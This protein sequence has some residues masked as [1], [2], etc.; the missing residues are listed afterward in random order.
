MPRSVTFGLLAALLATTPA[1][2]T[3][4][5]GSHVEA[6]VERSVTVHHRV[7]VTASHHSG[8]P[9]AGARVAV[10]APGG[11]DQPWTTG[12]CDANGRFAFDL[13][14]DSSGEWRVTVLE[15]GHGGSIVLTVTDQETGPQPTVRAEAT[16]APRLS[17]LQ[18]VVMGGCVV[19]GLAG[20][21]LFF[22]RRRG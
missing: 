10:F 7:E 11:G 12:A 17:P 22:T 8:T 4:A 5:H 6:V 14:P 1:A 9:M 19:W 21:A 15:R 13:P 18:M 16:A 2:T 20:T 3:H